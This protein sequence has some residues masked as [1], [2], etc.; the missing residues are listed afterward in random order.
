MDTKNKNLKL[1]IYAAVIIESF[2]MMLFLAYKTSPLYISIGGDPMEYKLGGAAILDGLTIFKDIFHQKGSLFFFIEAIGE[3]ICRLFNDERIG[4]F[5]IETLNL[6]LMVS[7]MYFPSI[8]YFESQH[9]SNRKKYGYT[10]AII[11]VCLLYFFTRL[12]GGNYNEEYSL[13]YNIIAI[14]IALEFATRLDNGKAYGKALFKPLYALFIGACFAVSV[15]IRFTN[16]AVIGGVIIF[17]GIVLIKNKD[18][19]TIFKSIGLGGIGILIVMLPQFVY[20]Y[21]NDALSEMLYQT[22]TYNF[23][24]LKEFSTVSTLDSSLKRYA[25]INY[26]I[27][28]GIFILSSLVYMISKKRY[29]AGL[30]VL[31]SLINM[32]MYFSTSIYLSHYLLLEIPVLFLSL[33]AVSEVDNKKF[34]RTVLSISMCAFLLYFGKTYYQ[35]FSEYNT[36]I[37][38]QCEEV[39]Q[40]TEDFYTETLDLIDDDKKNDMLFVMDFH[41]A[42][43]GY[44]HF[45]RYPFS[46]YFSVRFFKAQGQN[47]FVNN[48]YEDYKNKPPKYIVVSE[49]CLN[50]TNSEEIYITEDFKPVI[51]DLPKRYSLTYTD[52]TYTLYALK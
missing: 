41:D 22:F 51:D 33:L 45:G 10:L 3:Y 2:L 36:V 52:G 17:I 31:V 25:F 23:R 18:F 8:K 15:S 1:I 29:T 6:F 37:K 50:K 5:I 40:E 38:P 9:I 34:F 35:F 39:I 27:I 26:L 28:I 47:E 44:Y 4:T 48:F 11:N 49:E 7:F 21:L 12:L 42:I 19:K 16:A 20:Y 43:Y 32:L 30:S 14:I 46:P 13:P 24:Y